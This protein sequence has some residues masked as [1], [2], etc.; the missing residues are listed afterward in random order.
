MKK[1]KLDIVR[2][3]RTWLGTP[4]H[5]QGRLKGVGVD[6]VGIIIGVGKELGIFDYDTKDYARSPNSNR[7]QAELDFH[8]DR[9]PFTEI[10]AGDIGFF[11]FKAEPQHLA[12]FTDIGVLH[13]YMQVGKCVEHSYSSP[14]PERF[15][16]AYR[17]KGIK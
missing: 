7:M 10:R 8:F 13:A 4:Y 12:F 3:A 16:Q 11:K 15:V 2:Q 9:V 14:W 5:H 1:K 17:F 6:C